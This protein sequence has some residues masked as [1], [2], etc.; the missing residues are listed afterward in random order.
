[1][2]SCRRAP[3]PIDAARRHRL[4]YERM[5]SAARN[6]GLPR[7]YQSRGLGSTVRGGVGVGTPRSTLE[8]E[9]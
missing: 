7:D 5:D 1:M 3:V 4:S 2:P 8:F 9:P 6:R